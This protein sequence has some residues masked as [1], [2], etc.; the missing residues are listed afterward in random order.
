MGLL[1]EMM[2]FKRK[3]PAIRLMKNGFEIVWKFGVAGEV[4]E[5]CHTSSEFMGR[6]PS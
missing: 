2:S 5:R 6:A 4:N 1:D 3:A